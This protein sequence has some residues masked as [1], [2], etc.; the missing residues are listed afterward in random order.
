MPIK[1][2]LYIEDDVRMQQ[3]TDPFFSILT[4]AGF[5]VVVARTGED[6]WDKLSR[7]EYDGI[8]IDIMLPHQGK[9][10]FS[11]IPRYRTGIHLLEELQNLPELSINK[12]TPLVVVSAIADLEDIR[13]IK[14][15]VGKEKYLEKPIRPLEFLE[16]VKKMLDE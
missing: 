12:E 15:K 1:K 3:E 4:E 13:V 8:I 10:K 14:K 5:E 11:D 9:G 2:L 16:A 7:Q 6:G